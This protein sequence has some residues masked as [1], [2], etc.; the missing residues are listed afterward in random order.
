[1]ITY[2]PNSILLP[3][4]VLQHPS[5]F[6]VVSRQV[7]KIYEHGFGAEYLNEEGAKHFILNAKFPYIYDVFLAGRQQNR[8]IALGFNEQWIDDVMSLPQIW[9][10]GKCMDLSLI[11][12]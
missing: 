6:S 12:I 9:C 1:M 5:V 2:T 11:H 3:T 10:N 8:I 7:R 4:E